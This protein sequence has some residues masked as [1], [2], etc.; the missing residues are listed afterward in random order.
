MGAGGTS[1]LEGTFNQT[2]AWRYG[3]LTKRGFG[4]LRPWRRMLAKS[5]VNIEF[6]TEQL[7]KVGRC[8]LTL[9]NPR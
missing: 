7:A 6:Q 9:S 1:V 3:H 8:R 2:E 4:G 5:D